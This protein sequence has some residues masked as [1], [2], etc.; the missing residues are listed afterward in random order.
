MRNICKITFLLLF[1]FNSAFSQEIEW[2]NTIGGI[3]GDKLKCTMRNNDGGVIL[4]GYSNSPVSGDKT[5]VNI[6]GD[7]FWIVKIDS[8]G[9]IQWQRTL[10]GSGRDRLTSIQKVANGGLVLGGYSDSDSSGNK[11]EA[12]NGSYDY[13][14]VKIDS[15]GIIQ[16]QNTIG[17]SSYDALYSLQ[18]TND[19]LIA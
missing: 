2:Q 17:G 10:G 9:N 4:A 18:S 3:Y 16:W 19:A 8:M 13:W 1:V 7:D 11:S 15:N 6:G 14:I 5:E 12:S